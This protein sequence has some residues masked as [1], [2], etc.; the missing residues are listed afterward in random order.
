MS[1]PLAAAIAELVEALRD[2]LRAEAPAAERLL[3]IAETADRLSVGRTRVY[4]EMGA[5]R[6]R[7]LKSGRRRL[8]PESAIA[9]FLDSGR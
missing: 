2:E 4:A 9:A 5:G 8:I 7:S 3:S 1:D 6:L